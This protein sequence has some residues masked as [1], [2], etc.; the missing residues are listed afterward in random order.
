M[1]APLDDAYSGKPIS[2]V[3]G[4]ILQQRNLAERTKAINIR[5]VALRQAINAAT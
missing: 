3:A 1:K 5:K 2:L 4:V